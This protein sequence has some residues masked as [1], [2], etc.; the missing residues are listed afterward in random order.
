MIATI[1]PAITLAALGCTYLV[2]LRRNN[3]HSSNSSGAASFHFAATVSAPKFPPPTSLSAPTSPPES[4]DVL[5]SLGYTSELSATNSPQDSLPIKGEG[6]GE[7][8][9]QQRDATAEA[10]LTVIRNRHMSM[11][12]LVVFVVYATVSHTLFGAFVC[13]RIGDSSY[14][15]ADYSLECECFWCVAFLEI[16]S[17]W[18]L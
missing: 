9:G 14:L 18:L 15:R 3:H 4:R 5:T 16:E 6:S 12:L 7:E 11:A 17:F 10:V 8:Q 2:A 1:S 13:D